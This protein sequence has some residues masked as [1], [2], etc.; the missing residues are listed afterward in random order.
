VRRD[1]QQH[2]DNKTV[3]S[4]LDQLE[5]WVGGQIFESFGGD[6]LPACL[7]WNSNCIADVDLSDPDIAAAVVPLSMFFTDCLNK[8]LPLICLSMHEVQ[9]RYKLADSIE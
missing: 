1:A 2:I 5:L 3:F 9:F 7:L 4:W 6:T 8:Q